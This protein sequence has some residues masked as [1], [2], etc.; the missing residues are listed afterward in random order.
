MP[1]REPKIPL[2]PQPQMTR[3][4]WRSLDGAW[5][6]AYDD[7]ARWRNPS[8]VAFD[9]RINVPF[10]PESP[11]SGIGDPSF[12]AVVWYRRRVK[13]QPSERTQRLLLHFGAVDYQ[14]RV[15]CNGQLVTEH[16][17]GHT[18]FTVD[19]TA[20][21]VIDAEQEIVVR[22]CDNPHDLAK[23]RG[24]Q[25][26]HEQ[27]H[28]IW[29]PRTTGIWQ[30]VWLEPVP[31]TYIERLRWTPHLDHWAI[32]LSVLLDGPGK[33]CELR[34]RLASLSGEVLADDRY[35]MTHAELSRSIA[36]PD[37][38]I[39]DYRNRL[40]WSPE[41]PVLIEAD[42]ELWQG[43]E[44]IDAVHSYTAL[45]SVGTEGCRFMLNGRPYYLRM[46]LDQG[47][48]P[49]THLAPPSTDAL[50]RDVELVKTLGFNAVRKHQKLEDPRWL[51]FCDRL[52]LLVW[53]EMPSPYRFTRIAVERLVTEWME[54]VQR[55]S[56]HP[57]IAAWV[58]LNES[59]GVPDLPINPAHRDYVRTLYNLTKTLDPDRP[60]VGN[61]GWEH[62]A[63]DFI[64]IHDY[65][66]HPGVLYE[67][68]ASP[69]S[70]AKVL[71]RQQPG[72]RPLTVA[73]FR[74][75]DMPVILSEFGGIAYV[76]QGEGGW[77]YSRAHG[78]AEF[79]QAYSDLLEA[80]HECSGLAGFCYT[81]LTDTFQEKNGLLFADRT[82]K[83]DPAQLARATR[84]RRNAFAMDVNPDLPSPEPKRWRRR[85][86]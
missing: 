3:E 83:A 40:L 30:T 54:A 50:R 14:A 48:W 49:E 82:P 22:A 59:W 79:L 32:G 19:L 55:D 65:A 12:H 71:E 53:G 7:E 23:P 46:V 38:G 33:G 25:D 16:R 76:P 29:Y 77:G 80:I 10:P 27:P 26:W 4:A 42:L 72:G 45:R 31:E 43:G 9:R 86:G 64:T 57:C 47:Y 75:G 60:V 68:Y 11:A 34:V 67:R 58:P 1:K 35:T 69:E 6:F 63:T 44:R 84:G 61:D 15:W 37:P 56:S 74:V 13:L 51:Y 73:G 2:H 52:G 81:Q 62:V 17:G 70:V 5:E 21:L 85:G 20:A 36:L 24:K 41:N 28:E 8:E 66:A 18:P 78:E 39:D